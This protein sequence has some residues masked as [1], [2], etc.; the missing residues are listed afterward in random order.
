MTGTNEAGESKH[1]KHNDLFIY[2]LATRW[3]IQLSAG[4]KDRS[5]NWRC[6]CGK[7]QHLCVFEFVSQRENTNNQS[8]DCSK[9]SR[10]LCMW[11]ESIFQTFLFHYGQ[12]RQM[13]QLCFDCAFDS[14][15][16]MSRAFQIHCCLLFFWFQKSL[17]H[18]LQSQLLL[19]LEQ[20]S[21]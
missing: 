9:G 7:F 21:E 14:R 4:G 19:R 3:K 5:R 17:P 6:Q 8:S 13:L 18:W 16:F 2:T 10:G 15:A 20:S 12:S 11:N 1:A